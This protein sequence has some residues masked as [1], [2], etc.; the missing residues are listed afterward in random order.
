[1]AGWSREKRETVERAF[2]AFLGKSVIYSKDYGRICLGDHLYWGQRHTITQIFDA[3]ERDVHDIYI[4]KSR[5]LGMSTLVRALI[6]FFEGMFPGL[7][8]AI[9][10]DTDQNKQEA[11]AEL[12]VM[13]K[14]LPKNLKFPRIVMSNKRIGISLSNESKVLFMSAGVRKSKTSGTLGRSVGLSLATLSELC[15][16]DNEEGLEAFENSLSDVN[17]NRLYIRESTAR[18]FNHWWEMWKEAR[19]DPRHKCCI[20]L[21]WWCKDSQRIDKTD[22]DYDVF[23]VAPPE[24]KEIE[25]MEA[26]RKLYG[27]QV[28]AEQLAWI[29]RKMDPNYQQRTDEAEGVEQDANP[30]R[31]QEQPWTEEE[32]FQ[33]SG[34]VFF[35]ANKLTEITQRFVSHKYKPYMFWAGAEF[36]DMKVHP[37]ENNRM[38]ELKVWE[39]PDPEG[40]YTIGCDPAFG[41]NEKNDRSSIQVYRCYGDGIDQVAEYAW[42]LVTTSQLAWVLAALMGW[43]GRGNAEVRYILELNGPGGAVFEELKRLK[44]KI[45]IQRSTREIQ[46]KGLADI[47]QNVRTYIF[48][49]NDSMFQG[50]AWHFKTN[51][52]TKVQLMERFRD[53]VS[54]GKCRIRSLALI[55]EMKTVARDGDS[56]EAP[57]NMKDDRVIAS[58]LACHNWEAKMM[59]NL[60]S[61]GKTR[62][63]EERRSRL[64]M[65][66]QVALFQQN[67][68]ESFFKSKNT[69]RS[70]NQQ[71]AVRQAWRAGARPGWSR[72]ARPSW[73]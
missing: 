24:E 20:F 40:S 72:A 43:Y 54:N 69:A 70:T 44:S 26:V 3:L 15:S 42:P 9:V 10:F 23:G 52:S 28:V 12:E 41:E 64:S 56:I 71:L 62:E 2:Y 14:E 27:Y 1:M 66:D 11:Q 16:Y 37:A 60:L 55:E 73:R 32:A 5:Q 29:R 49:R 46:D 39:E 8:G 48:S 6:M 50:Y 63:F 13:I 19:K 22:A 7:K 61:Q 65:V 57:G 31:I 68:L 67:Q 59:K 4:L 18:G 58:A 30:L 51:I 33:Q 47:F 21:G 53:F 35:A 45:E 25:K 17:P 36:V 34:S 38:T